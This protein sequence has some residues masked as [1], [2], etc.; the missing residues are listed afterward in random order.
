MSE[1]AS[2]TTPAVPPAPTPAPEPPA[3]PPTP[4]PESVTP[5]P[6]APAQPQTPAASVDELPPWAQRE[7]KKLRDENAGNRV[8]AKENS[9]R[10]AAFEA[11]QEQQ[12]QA[13]AK[14]LGLVSDE[15]PTAEQLTEQLNATKSERDA[16]QARA[17][18]TAVELAVFR[19]AAAEQVD[20]NAL[21]DSRAFVSALDGLDPSAPDFG[22]QVKD[23]IATAAEANSRYKLVPPAPTAPPA[24]EPPSVPKSG[25]EFGAPPQGPRQWTEA[26]VAAATPAQTQEAINKGLLVNLGFG[27]K[28]SARR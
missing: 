15:P 20:G 5:A 24:P 6:P 17:R 11:A 28:R 7:I 26:D 23:A 4:T 10:L 2:E 27:P 9:D 12:R 21:L 3:T 18:Q 13:M 14:A 25:A 1:P 22:Q 16:E 8:Q 19:A